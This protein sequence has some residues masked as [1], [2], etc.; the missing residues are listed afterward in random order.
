MVWGD[1]PMAQHRSFMV[2]GDGPKAQNR[3]FT[4]SGDGPK[5]QIHSFMV[6]GDGPKVQKQ[7]RKGVSNEQSEGFHEIGAKAV[8]T[9]NR[10]AMACDQGR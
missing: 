2:S 3:S 4:V 5:A 10:F 8:G 6:S 1:S 9:P 7:A